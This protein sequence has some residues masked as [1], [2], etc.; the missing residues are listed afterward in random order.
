[1]RI[2]VTVLALLAGCTSERVWGGSDL[3]ALAEEASRYRAPDELTAELRDTDAELYAYALLSRGQVNEARSVLRARLDEIEG[4]ALDAAAHGDP[5]LERSVVGGVVRLKYL[6][7]GRKSA[8][9]YYESQPPSIRMSDQLSTT[10]CS[11]Q[12]MTYAEWARA[13]WVDAFGSESSRR[14]PTDEERQRQDALFECISE[15]SS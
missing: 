3:E 11:V 4:G 7:S 14:W 8:L 13:Y 5:T 12:Q 9:R 15:W 10:V 6:L 2:W 1:M